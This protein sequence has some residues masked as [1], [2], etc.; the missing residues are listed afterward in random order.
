M[1]KILIV[2]LTFIIIALSNIVLDAKQNVYTKY[3]KEDEMHILTNIVEENLLTDEFSHEVIS[4]VNYSNR[5]VHV[6]LDKMGYLIFDR[7]FQDY[8]EFS[9][10]SLSPF[11]DAKG[12]KVYFGPTYYFT[13]TNNNYSD[14]IS[15]VE[16]SN[17][18]VNQF[19]KQELLNIEEFTKEKALCEKEEL[20]NTSQIMNFSNSI[21]TEYFKKLNANIGK[22]YPDLFP[23]SCA[24][25]AYGMILAYYDSNINDGFIPENFDV[26]AYQVFES[27]YEVDISSFAESP[28]IDGDHGGFHEFLLNHAEEL[29]LLGHGN[30]YFGMTMS[31]IIE[32]SDWYSSEIGY[33]IT[34]R[35]KGIF[36]SKTQFTK[37]A[38]DDGYPV[39][40]SISGGED[41][42]IGSEDSHAVVGYDYNS[43]GI[44]VHFGA[45][46]S[47]LTEVNIKD[48]TINSVCYFEVNKQHSHSYNY[49]YKAG[50]QQGYICSC[51]EYHECN[52]FSYYALGPLKHKKVCNY[53]N[54]IIEESHT[55]VHYPS[56]TVCSLCGYISPIQPFS[57]E[58]RYD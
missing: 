46:G 15:N 55:W 10:S 17:T 16:I 39:Y 8:S 33:A 50:I 1:K 5:Y 41:L 51:Y 3:L 53:C 54:I 32:L 45:Q 24:T 42:W 52:N 28:G 11:K 34:P 31:D 48:Y 40:I 2:L 35:K 19:K 58:I 22:N 4:S 21:N 9:L 37:N 12:R 44:I 30:T 6:E 56:Q 36:I 57:L 14:V 13:V 23:N 49:N 7:Y 25:V 18:K 20:L 29:D 38:I 26:R 27:I 43:S 47:T